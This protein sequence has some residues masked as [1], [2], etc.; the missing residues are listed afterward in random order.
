MKRLRSFGLGERSLAIMLKE[1]LMAEGI[2]CLIRNEELFAA[3]GEIPFI[4]CQPE[5]WV[6]DNEVFPR[7]KK[8]LDAWLQE[9]APIGPAW[10]CP[11][12]G[13]VLEGQFGACWNCG[14][15]REN[16]EA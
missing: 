16:R 13:E 11:K 1:L 12:C 3:M 10:V 5:L 7:A 8:L 6:V 14:R 9:D 4:E 2:H 15:P